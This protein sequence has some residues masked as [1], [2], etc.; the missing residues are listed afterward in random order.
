MAIEPYASPYTPNLVP[1]TRIEGELT[2]EKIVQQLINLERYLA[3]EMERIEEG[4]RFVPVQ[5][6]YGALLVDPGPAPDQPLLKGVPTPI[7]GFNNFSPAVPNRV[8][9]SAIGGADSLQPLEGGVY[10]VQTQITADIDSGTSYI[11]TVAING[12]LTGIF[13]AVAASNQTDIVTLTLYGLIALNPGDLVTVVVVATAA[14]AGP[15][16]F[17]MTSATFSVVRISEEHD[18]P[19]LF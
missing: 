8:T 10:W 7:E 15:F 13:G 19:G 2:P 12:T 6:A 11:I 9:A 17:I 14:P 16:Q 18:E 4:L 3:E 5:A 1:Q